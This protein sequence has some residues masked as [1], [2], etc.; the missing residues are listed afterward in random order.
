MAQQ[1]RALS[2]FAKTLSDISGT[3]MLADNHL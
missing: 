2:A 1:L 3:H